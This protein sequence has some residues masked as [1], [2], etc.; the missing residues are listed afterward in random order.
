VTLACLMAVE[1]YRKRRYLAWDSRRERV[2][3]A[4]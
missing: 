3:R 2:V 1:S 4:S